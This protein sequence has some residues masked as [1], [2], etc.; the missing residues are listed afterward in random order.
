MVLGFATYWPIG[1]CVIGW[2]MLQKRGY[3]GGFDRWGA[4]V[5]EMFA[6]AG[7]ASTPG[8]RPDWAGWGSAPSGNAA[9]DEWRTSEIERLDAERRKLDEARREFSAFADQARRARDKEEFERFMAHRP[10]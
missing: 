1:F 8:M 7:P 2:K 4:N 6:G 5:R 9:F 10:S 3:V